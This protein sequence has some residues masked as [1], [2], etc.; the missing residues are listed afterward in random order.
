MS[1][2]RAVRNGNESDMLR[3]GIAGS[4]KPRHIDR[5]HRMAQKRAF[6]PHPRHFG[7]QQHLA[8]ASSGRNVAEGNQPSAPRRI[9][10]MRDDPGDIYADRGMLSG[11]V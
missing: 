2:S 1:A 3:L 11:R 4:E 10:D 9:R 6:P 5:D 7:R 8:A